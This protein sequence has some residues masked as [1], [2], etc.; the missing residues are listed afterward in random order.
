MSKEYRILA[1]RGRMERQKKGEKGG[2]RKVKREAEKRP[3]QLVWR[4][5]KKRRKK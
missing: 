4:P 3:C 5:C 1:N 2:R